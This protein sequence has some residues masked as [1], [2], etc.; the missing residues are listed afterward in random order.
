LYRFRSV[1]LLQSSPSRDKLPLGLEPLT[2]YPGSSDN[3]SRVYPAHDLAYRKAPVVERQNG[4]RGVVRKTHTKGGIV[5]FHAL[6]ASQRLFKAESGIN[7]L[8]PA[9]R[10]PSIYSVSALS[11]R[12]EALEEVTV[13]CVRQLCARC[14]RPAVKRKM[15]AASFTIRVFDHLPAAAGK[16]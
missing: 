12:S 7:G 8:L 10:V 13:F 4:V 9:T 6:S 1:L 2:W 15:Y 16:P 3:P 14:S 5:S 11:R